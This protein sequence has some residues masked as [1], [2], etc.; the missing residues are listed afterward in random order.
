M[1][2]KSKKGRGIDVC[3]VRDMEAAMGVCDRGYLL[4]GHQEQRGST[5]V[6]LRGVGCSDSAV[7]SEGWS[8]EIT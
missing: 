3:L 8:E 1:H 6:E 5:V 7:F 4:L 2:R